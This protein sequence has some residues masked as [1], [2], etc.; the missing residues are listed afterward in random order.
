MNAI[1][2]PKTRVLL[3][4]FAVLML[5]TSSARAASIIAWG[6]SATRDTVYF[7]FS[8]DVA[9]DAYRAAVRKR[10]VGIVGTTGAHVHYSTTGFADS[11]S[12][13]SPNTRY[14]LIVQIR[15]THGGPWTTQMPR[16]FRTLP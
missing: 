1:A 13:L 2:S 10:G 16:P 3:A 11:I 8:T 15:W 4:L 9:P 14:L 7:Q 5:F 12:G 6:H